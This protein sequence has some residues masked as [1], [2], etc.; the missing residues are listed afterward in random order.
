MGLGLPNGLYTS[1]MSWVYCI[2]RISKQQFADLVRLAATVG[3]STPL[4]HFGVVSIPKRYLR[5]CFYG[6]CVI[7][8]K[9]E[10]TSC[11]VLI[12]TPVHQLSP[13]LH[14]YWIRYTPQTPFGHIHGRKNE[15]S[16]ILS[17]V[18]EPSPKTVRSRLCFPSQVPNPPC[19]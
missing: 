16:E 14:S 2:G 15:H 11:Y 9:S 1:S 10:P 8:C 5:S 6:P 18:K 7:V 19:V 12:V 17:T 4:V 3:I 13:D